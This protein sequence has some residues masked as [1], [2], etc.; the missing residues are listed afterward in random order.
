M[1]RLRLLTSPLPVPLSW[2]A[3][4]IRL[5]VGF[6][7]ME[8]GYAKLARGPEDFIGVLHAIG[9]PFSF[10]AGWAT[11]VVEI[12]GGLLIFIGAFVP[13]FFLM[14]RRPPRSTLFPYP[15]LFDLL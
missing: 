8:H 5:I 11:I 14:M 10:L 15:T 4:P 2:Y 3:I 13:L 9:V 1:N 7:F 12:V 6:G